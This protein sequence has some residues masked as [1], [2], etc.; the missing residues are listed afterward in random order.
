[1]S[2]GETQLSVLLS[3]MQ[4]VLDSTRYVF[5]TLPKAQYGDHADWQ[6]V[7]SVQESEGLTLVVPQVVADKQG[8]S[9]ASPYAR[10]SLSVHSSLEAVGLT[11]AFANTLKA[12][13]ISAN[14]IAGF[15]H[16]HIYVQNDH[17]RTALT[18]LQTLS[19]QHNR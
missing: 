4:P 14:V 13:N 11:A 7:A 1:M 8:L 3:T 9:Y 6:P 5:I 17:A 15:F 12:E 10:I 18:A 2:L 19:N 16:D